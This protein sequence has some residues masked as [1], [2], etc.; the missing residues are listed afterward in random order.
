MPGR[1]FNSTSYK[2]GFN[3][4]E[5]LDEMSVDGGDVD[6]DARIYDSRTGRFLSVDPDAPK[7]PFMSPYCFAAN[8]PI[9]LIDKNGRG[10]VD[11]RTGNRISSNV[12]N[13]ITWGY[14]YTRSNHHP[15]PFAKDD[16]LSA[17]SGFGQWAAD[18]D[19]VYNGLADKEDNYYKDRNVKAPFYANVAYDG[20]TE[21]FLINNEIRTS[22][23]NQGA[24]HFYNGS[25]SG[26]YAFV[27]EDIIGMNFTLTEVQDGWIHQESN[28]TQKGETNEYYL[29]K[30]TSFTV[31]LQEAATKVTKT[32]NGKTGSAMVHTTTTYNVT[33]YE[34]TNTYDESGKVTGS[35]QKTYSYQ[36]EKTE[37][38]PE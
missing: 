26:N 16:D 37:S 5:K 29:S 9:K 14:V 4:K 21:S 17:T 38:K 7:Y 23:G 31:V 6:F 2:Y 24:E 33:V 25:Q 35:E 3:G 1:T 32:Y 28:F 30:Q 18:D 36:K 20:K 27:T 19:P 12:I 22:K 15:G 34:T 11:P 10:P 13:T 8:D